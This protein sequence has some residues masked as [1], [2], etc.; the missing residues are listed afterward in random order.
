MRKSRQGVLVERVTNVK[1]MI[2]NE[3]KVFFILIKCIF[4]KKKSRGFWLGKL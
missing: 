4:Y 1:A 2:E 3:S